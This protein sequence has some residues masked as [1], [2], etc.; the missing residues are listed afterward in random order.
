MR[1][2]FAPRVLVLLMVA[3]FCVP[4]V[5]SASQSPPGDIPDNQA[6][7]QYRG[8]GYSLKTP[9]GWNR[10]SKGQT[11]TFAD[12]YNAISVQTVAGTSR[13]TVASITRDL[14]KLKTATPGFAHPKISLINRPAGSV[15]LVTYE[16]TSAPNAVTGKRL[17][18]AVERYAYWYHG[19]TAVLTLQAPKGS[20]NVDAWKLVSTSFTWGK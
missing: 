18:N 19:V 17:V 3:A 10:T 13:P 4:A 6:F 20:D 8:V 9:E 12:K 16:A 11:V 7:V 15:V 1:K 5:A 14:S 2:P